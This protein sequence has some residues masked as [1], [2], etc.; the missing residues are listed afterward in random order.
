M[1]PFWDFPRL[2]TV[3]TAFVLAEVGSRS[4]PANK[5]NAPSPKSVPKHSIV[6]V[7][8]FQLVKAL[9]KQRISHPT[10]S[11]HGQFVGHV[12]DGSKVAILVKDEVD[13]AFQAPAAPVCRL[14]QKFILLR[15]NERSNGVKGGFLV[16]QDYEQR[17]LFTAHIRKGKIAGMSDSIDG[18]RGE[19]PQGGQSRGVEAASGAGRSHIGNGQK[20]PCRVGWREFLDIQAIFSNAE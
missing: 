11:R 19:Q 16:G 17:L 18:L 3:R 7:L 4:S 15:H 8:F 2:V 10:A 13:T 5:K 9:H 1:L 12:T 20:R 14:C 6:A